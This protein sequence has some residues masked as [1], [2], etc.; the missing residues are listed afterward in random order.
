MPLFSMIIYAGGLALPAQL[1]AHNIGLESSL[2]LISY[3]YILTMINMTMRLD[4]AKIREWMM[5]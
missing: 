4:G 3:I 2:L 5:P 1:P